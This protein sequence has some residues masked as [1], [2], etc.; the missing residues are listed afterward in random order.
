[1]QVLAFVTRDEERSLRAS[2]PAKYLVT[3]FR[4]AQDFD[5]AIAADPFS[6]AVF[7]PTLHSVER[8]KPLLSLLT[9]RAGG[10]LMVASLT[11]MPTRRILD[12]AKSGVCELILADAELDRPTIARRMAQMAER[13]ALAML[14]QLLAD[15][16]NR[17]PRIL[18]P[19]VISFFGGSTV[20]ETVKELANRVPIGLKTLRRRVVGAGIVRASRLLVGI[21]VAR[22][23]ELLASGAETVERV[24][25]LAGYEN[26]QRMRVHY[27]AVFGKSPRAVAREY[28]T[29]R[30]SRELAAYLIA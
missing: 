22:T 16:I 3:Y 9:Q 14:F 11:A 23:W 12:L 7:D 25:G 29:S 5:A 24:A 20:P 18:Q 19:H 6:P 17:M 8:F 15:N 28:D 10:A 30:F 13:S 21:R 2:L 27:A 26:S 1:M 4:V